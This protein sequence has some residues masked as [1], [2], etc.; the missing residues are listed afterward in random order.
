MALTI[1]NY[2]SPGA[3]STIIPNP[4]IAT[5]Q[6]TPIV[7]VVGQ[8]LYGSYDPI[9]FTNSGD[10]QSAY[11]SPTQGNPLALGI[12]LAFLNGAPQVL[13]L[14]VEPDNNTPAYLSVLVS[15]L[16]TSSYSA[17]PSSALDAVSNL[18][19]NTSGNVVGT[20]YI[21]DFNP[22]VPDPIYN[23]SAQATRQAYALAGSSSMLQYENYISPT[24]VPLANTAQ[25]QIVVYT[26][27]T[28]SPPVSS[29]TQGSWNQFL[30]ATA[31]LNAFNN[32][33]LSP[34]TAQLVV[35]DSGQQ[36]VAPYGQ[37]ELFS[38]LSLAEGIDS[39][40]ITTPYTINAGT[41]NAV[42]LT[43]NVNNP[44]YCQNLV[45]TYGLGTSVGGSSAGMMKL[46]ISS[47]EGGTQHQILL[48]LFDSNTASYANASNGQAFGLPVVNGVASNPYIVFVSGT[49][50]VVT[51]TSF[52]NALTQLE[53]VRADIVV[54][55]NTNPGI[56]VALEEHCATMSSE[57]ERNERI[58]ITSGPVT[59]LYTTT[60]QN[61]TALQGGTGSE[62]MVYIWP[63]S[64]YYFDTILNNT[65][66]LDGTYLACACAGIL[67]SAD[68]ATP[69]T[70][71]I[72]S[73]FR[74]VGVHASETSMDDIAQYGISI[75]ENN[76]TYGLRVRH[77]LTCNPTTT[78]T[79]EIS[80]VRQ[81]DFVAQSLRDVMDAN[82]I[83]TKITST[84][85]ATVTTLA[86]T[87]LQGLEETNIIY[88]YQNVVARIDP[89]NPVQIDLSLT[90]RPAYPCDFVQITISVT[91]SLAGF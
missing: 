80:V 8:A 65:V 63:T 29:I 60:I 31:L 85:L 11:G 34:V 30:N 48:G 66:T 13:G 90:V 5:S 55:L 46:Y 77:G 18:P 16:P 67:T 49:N 71:K 3:Y 20:F 82:I 87:T 42:T 58:G 76:P 52:V 91:S 17:A 68:A 7:A 2:R 75:I 74:D 56:Q 83:A 84:T 32:A 53:T 43:Q 22:A 23:S 59:E 50:G 57:L 10:A 41:A 35:P 40:A 4:T 81:L 14:N 6:G 51:N 89:N 45:Y 70:H 86:T 21:Q 73:G 27:S 12:Q 72:L 39:G 33:Y 78:E 47:I 26:I 36:T 79:Q 44:T 69:L 54:V 38:L 25:Q 15:S 19:I 37:Y 64:A 1:Q 62:R 61:V 28:S 24:V 9:L 88:G